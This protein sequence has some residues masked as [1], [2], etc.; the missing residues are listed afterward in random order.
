M[1]P[2][3]AVVI[4]THNRLRYLREAC[5]SVFESDFEDWQLIVVDDGSTDGTHR[6]LQGLTD[7]RVA[8]LRIDERVERSAARN[9]GLELVTAPY[10]LFLDDD[11]LLTKCALGS[12]YAALALHSEVGASVGRRSDFAGEREWQEPQYRLWA[13][14]RSVMMDVMLGWSA[15]PSQAMFKVDLIKRVGGWSTGLVVAED[16]ELWL[17][18]APATLVRFLP[19]LVCRKRSHRDQWRPH[20]TIA[21][22]EQIRVAAIAS[23]PGYKRVASRAAMARA[24]V[25]KADAE[26]GLGLH[27]AAVLSVL[28]AALELR[29]HVL[30]PVT[31]VDLV[32]STMRI[33]RSWTRRRNQHT[34]GARASRMRVID[35]SGFTA[36]PP[37]H[38]QR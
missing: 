22:K 20:D 15:V 10:V 18:L 2:A 28:E 26:L 35:T 19:T 14:S 25:L 12:H 32:Q 29:G 21:V 16:H 34:P 37:D 33:L 31:S 9:Q 30:S 24:S 3:V 7:R 38:P 23:N 6:W 13:T 36:R 4:S 11:D 1:K 8:V 5:A 17:R 27:L